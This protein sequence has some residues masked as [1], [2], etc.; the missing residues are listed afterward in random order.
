MEPMQP[1]KIDGYVVP[2]K[3]QIEEYL[4]ILKRPTWTGFLIWKRARTALLRQGYIRWDAEA[5]DPRVGTPGAY[6]AMVST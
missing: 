5:V 6:V 2:V 1:L 3:A 4:G